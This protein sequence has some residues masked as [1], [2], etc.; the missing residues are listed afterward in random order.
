MGP[1]RM[2][3]QENLAAFWAFNC[4]TACVRPG[5]NGVEDFLVCD[6]F[7]F[8]GANQRTEVTRTQ[9]LHVYFLRFFWKL[10]FC[11]LIGLKGKHV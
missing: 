8:L 9:K 4:G 11:E 6:V 5:Q 2:E 1:N 7:V 3:G 10:L